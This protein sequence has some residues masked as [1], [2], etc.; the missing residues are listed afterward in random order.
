MKKQSTVVSG[1]YADFWNFEQNYAAK[2]PS[3]FPHNSS[4][5]EK[6]KLANITTRHFD[7]K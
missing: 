2:L 5:L 1:L 3:H 4:T 7:Y 6:K